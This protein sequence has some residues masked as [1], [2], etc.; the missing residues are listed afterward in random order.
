MHVAHIKMIF[1]VCIS[2][3]YRDSLL[4]SNMVVNWERFHSFSSTR[5]YFILLPTKPRGQPDKAVTSILLKLD[6]LMGRV[7][8]TFLIA[9]PLNSG[10]FLS[11]SFHS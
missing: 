9:D 3:N 2:S 6:E 4:P 5:L 7:T 8:I 11:S 1:H 10:N